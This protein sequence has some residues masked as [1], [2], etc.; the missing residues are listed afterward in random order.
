MLADYSELQLEIADTLHR[1]DL[2]SKI[3]TFISLFEKRAN[4]NLR[5][6]LQ[7]LTTTL[8]LSTGT[9]SI[10]LPSDF[11]EFISATLGDQTYQDNIPHLTGETFDMVYLDTGCPI[12]CNIS[13]S[14][15]YFDRIA[16]RDYSII[17]RY[18]KGWDLETDNTNWLL[19]NYP[20]CYLYGSL[21]ASSVYLG[22]D[23]RLSIWSSLA[24][25]AINEANN[26]ATRTRSKTKRRVDSGLIRPGRFDINSGYSR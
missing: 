8:T 24:S 4:R 17:L 23:Q 19:D 20:D 9:S 22:E 3:P 6:L 26:I 2:T 11:I 1:N 12:H 10:A 14:T 13:G 21:A 16:D 7:E 5:T 15:I 25:A 18:I